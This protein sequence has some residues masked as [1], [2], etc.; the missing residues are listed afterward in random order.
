VAESVVAP[1]NRA[2]VYRGKATRERPRASLIGIAMPVK[3]K[4]MARAMFAAK[5]GNSTLGIPQSVGA[6]MVSDM[7]PGSV[8]K[9]PARAKAMQKRGRISNKVMD[10][11]GGKDQQGINASTR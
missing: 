8:K 6:E 3:S 5:A 11:Y 7:G 4:A 1:N 10:K 9:L 2:V